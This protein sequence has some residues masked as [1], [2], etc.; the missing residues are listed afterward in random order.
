MRVEPWLAATWLHWRQYEYYVDPVSP[1][2]AIGKFLLAD[3]WEHI[4]TDNVPTLVHSR[5]TFAESGQFHQEVY[6]SRQPHGLDHGA[7]PGLQVDL[8]D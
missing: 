1:D 5:I 4:G 6:D 3:I 8:S 2:P 7:G